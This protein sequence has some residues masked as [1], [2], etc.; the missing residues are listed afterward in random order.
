MRGS[1]RKDKSRAVSQVKVIWLVIQQGIYDPRV[2]SLGYTFEGV[3]RSRK[4][5]SE[6]ER[7]DGGEK[8]ISSRNLSNAAD[9]SSSS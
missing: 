8:R 7:S 9:S 5:E 6:R 4:L 1:E 2:T 3:H